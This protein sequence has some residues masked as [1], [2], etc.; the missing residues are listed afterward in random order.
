MIDILEH[1]N[2]IQRQVS[3][4]GEE[5]RVTLRRTYQ[6]EVE[7]V[8]DALTDP[9]RIRRWFMP[10]T[11]ELKVGGSFQ[12]EGNAGGEILECEPPDRFKVSFG[13]PASLVEIRL[14]PGAGDDTTELQMDHSV[15]ADF[16]GPSGALYVGPGWD[17]AL[18]GVALYVEGKLK[19]TDDPQQMANSPEVIEFNKASIRE[20]VKVLRD[21]GLVTPEELRAAAE[22]SANQFAPGTPVDDYL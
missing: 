13:G 11:G 10:I 16:G 7:D 5:V 22:A 14:S 1:I 4:T 2:A 12:L 20:W 18:L 15:P 19:E 6:A 21:S 17:G 9:D 8:W 3:K